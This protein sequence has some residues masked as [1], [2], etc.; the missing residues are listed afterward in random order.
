MTQDDIISSY[1]GYRPL[2]RP[3]KKNASTAKLSRTH[4]VLESPTGLVSTVGGKLTTYRHM[5]QDT[6][7]VLSK[8]D[9]QKLIHPTESLL[10]QG[11]ADWSIVRY[12]LQ[13][14]GGQTQGRQARSEQAQGI[15]P[16]G[17]VEHLGHS[18][19]SEARQILDLIAHDPTL[20][21][22]LIDDLPYIAAEVIYG[23][24]AEMAMTPNDILMRRTSITLED[25]QRGL[26]I[27]DEVAS[28]MAHEHNW[29]LS[30]Q[31][32]KARSYRETMQTQV[33]AETKL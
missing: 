19:G 22:Q 32:E 28:L 20:A 3:R 8:R 21:R 25:K 33:A 15:V 10:L 18:Y 5:A 14:S 11:S 12:E 2:I 7:D 29:S 27:V 30:E 26:G 31:Q 9:G 16:T 4:A 24:R 13:K 17:V 1:A 6:V 23:C